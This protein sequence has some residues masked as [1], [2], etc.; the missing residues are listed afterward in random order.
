MAESDALPARGYKA[1]P[2]ELHSLR[3]RN[4][5]GFFSHSEKFTLQ[6]PNYKLHFKYLLSVLLQN[7]RTNFSLLNDN[8][9]Y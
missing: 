6:H 5:G 9:F 4:G 2:S 3:K 1:G 7:V 8:I